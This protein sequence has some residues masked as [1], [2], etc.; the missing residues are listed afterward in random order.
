MAP[1]RRLLL[2]RIAVIPLVTLAFQGCSVKENREMCPCRLSL[3]ARGELVVAAYDTNWLFLDSLV[4]DRE[5]GQV[6]ERRVTRDEIVV[7]AFSGVNPEDITGTSVIAGKDGE[8]API[9]AYVKRLDCRRETVRDSIILHKQFANVILQ[10]KGQHPGYDFVVSSGVA[11]VD[12]LTL[13]PVKGD[14]SVNLTREHG[15]LLNFVL[16]RQVPCGSLSLELWK[17]G[18]MED[19][20]PMQEW[21]DRTGYDWNEPDLQ[22]L[23]IEL[24]FVNSVVSIRVNGW[25]EGEVFTETI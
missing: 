4:L 6:V 20:F 9:R 2:L 25:A 12:L 10:L 11:G 16:P 24:D 23:C 22:D 5:K 19:S 3:W 17:N 7:C 13:E 21:I 15:G 8:I 18:A 1:D 14:Y